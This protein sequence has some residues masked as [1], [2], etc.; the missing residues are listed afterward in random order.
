LMNRAARAG[1]DLVMP[2]GDDRDV[3]QLVQQLASEHLDLRI[4]RLA[5]REDPEVHAQ[6]EEGR[7]ALRG[8]KHQSG[9]HLTEGR[10]SFHGLARVPERGTLSNRAS[11]LCAKEKGLTPEGQTLGELLT[12]LSPNGQDVAEPGDVAGRSLRRRHDDT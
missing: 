1:P 9:F 6:L 8:G 12:A 4:R 2:L 3:V 7:L 5:T 10:L 11:A